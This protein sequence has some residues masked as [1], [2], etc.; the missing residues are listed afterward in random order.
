M[1]RA[2]TSKPKTK[3]GVASLYVVIFASI[4]LGIITLSFIRII[5][6]E[7]SKT[8]NDDLSQSA[9][10]SA[11]A[12]VEDAKAAMIKYYDCVAQGQ[13]AA[14]GL[15]D[16]GNLSCGE[17]IW[18]YN[19]YGQSSENKISCDTVSAM[20]GRNGTNGNHGEV[21]IEETGD[22]DA[23]N[24]MYQAYTCV[25]VTDRTEDYRSYLGYQNTVRIIPLKTDP[26]VNVT[27]VKLGWYSSNNGT[28]YNYANKDG[29]NSL[30]NSNA[31]TPPTISVQLIQ[32][33]QKFYL[34]ESDVSSSNATDRGTVFLVPHNGE[35]KTVIEGKHFIASNDKTPKNGDNSNGNAL[36]AVNCPA[37]S[38]KEFACNVVL[39][40]PKALMNGSAANPNYTSDLNYLVITLP[41]SQPTTDFSVRLC[42]DNNCNNTTDFTGVQIAVDST[43]RA[44]DLYRRVETR[45]ELADIYFPYPQFA[46]Q[47]GGEGED[48]LN[49]NFW[50]TRNCWTENGTCPN[51]GF[52]NN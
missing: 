39:R 24:N 26:G 6:S 35:G 19:N 22:S 17:I 13:T 8:S 15:T 18:L 23:N 16:D 27:G 2:T 52:I 48:T 14:S 12:G 10:D 28:S 49:K 11:L 4:L 38:D 33:G 1:K 50:V 3:R 31:A 20:L 44:N 40:F 25:K 36:F 42:T 30:N 7:V 9:Y 5:L 32:A 45:V 41:Y 46:V 37:N 21:V 51:S 29:F 34:A 43:G 47:L